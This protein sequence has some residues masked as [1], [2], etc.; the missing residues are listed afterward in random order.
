MLLIH[1]IHVLGSGEVWVLYLLSTFIYKLTRMY[2]DII[3]RIHF[4]QL[5]LFWCSWQI[6]LSTLV[7]T[8]N[9]HINLEPFEPSASI[10]SKS[11]IDNT[12]PLLKL[13]TALFL[14]RSLKS[15]G[16]STTLWDSVYI[17]NDNLYI[18]YISICTYT[19]I[20]W[21]QHD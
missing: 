14:L 20:S 18:R 17:Y 9:H 2:V 8:I 19:S 11:N 16:P 1:S 10:I 3:L 6:I 4:E 13:I 15:S 12:N 5:I 21:A 7:H